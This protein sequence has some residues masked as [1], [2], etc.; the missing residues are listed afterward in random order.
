MGPSWEKG[1]AYVNS[2]T[3]DMATGAMMGYGKLAMR[4]S[5]RYGHKICC[6]SDYTLLVSIT[7]WNLAYGK[8]SEAADQVFGLLKEADKYID[9][10][11]L[12]FGVA[13]PS[14]GSSNSAVLGCIEGLVFASECDPYE[15]SRDFLMHFF[16]VLN[17]GKDFFADFERNLFRLANFPL[18]L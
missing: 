2:H 7:S 4:V 16:K 17:S 3:C 6:V 9:S 8:V 10:T 15:K 14:R 11:L 12:W 1:P 5:A 18:R 13:I